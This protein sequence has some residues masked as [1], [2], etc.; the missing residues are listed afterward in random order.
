MISLLR[1]KISE[2]GKN[3]IILDV[4][5]VGY[6][7]RM[8]DKALNSLSKNDQII[9]VRTKMFFNQR[10]GVFEIYGFPKKEDLDIFELLTGISGIGPKSALHIVSSLEM[11]ELVMAVSREDDEYL[12]KVS[13]LGPKTAKRV[14]VELK[15]KINKADFAKF[16]EF[17]STQEG[18]AIDALVS[19]GYPKN[20]A[21]EAIRKI[22]SKKKGVENTVKEALKVLS[23]R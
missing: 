9:N 22:S 17:D 7:V 13:G 15:D 21:I 14:V 6:L 8:G 23:G 18:E 20:S 16:S 3:Y 19:L 11:K 12:R 4:S 5:G 1:G 2:V 10:E